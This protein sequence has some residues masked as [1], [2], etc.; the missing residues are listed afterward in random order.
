MQTKTTQRSTNRPYSSVGPSEWL[1]DTTS[2]S[3]VGSA[4]RQMTDLRVPESPAQVKSLFAPPRTM[5][6]PEDADSDKE[7]RFERYQQLHSGLGRRDTPLDEVKLGY[8][9][10]YNVKAKRRRI[11]TILSEFPKRVARQVYRLSWNVEV[12]SYNSHYAGQTGMAVGAAMYVL[13]D[14]RQ[15]ALDGDAIR[16]WIE[17][18]ARPL[19]QEHGID[20]RELIEFTFDQLSDDDD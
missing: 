18:V 8:R 2:Q 9:R 7:D 4:D 14:S 17:E 11:D 6:N 19:C 1:A 5:F 3:N 12:K 13:A 10:D 20:Y 15:G 16:G